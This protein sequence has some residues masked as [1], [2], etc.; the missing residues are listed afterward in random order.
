MLTDLSP[1]HLLRQLLFTLPDIFLHRIGL[2]LDALRNLMRSS[3]LQVFGSSP[4]VLNSATGF[5]QFLDV[6]T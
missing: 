3:R 6:R 5:F 1:A 4:Q 2:F